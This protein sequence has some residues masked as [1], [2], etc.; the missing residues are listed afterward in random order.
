MSPTE[1]S[2][3]AGFA[4]SDQG[5]LPAVVGFRQDRLET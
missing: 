3:S 4:E 2:L 5:L 1:E